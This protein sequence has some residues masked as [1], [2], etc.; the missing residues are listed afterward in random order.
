MTERYIEQVNSENSRIKS[1]LFDLTTNIY[2]ISETFILND[3]L[4]TLLSRQYTDETEVRKYFD[5]YKEIENILSQQTAIYKLN[6]YTNNASIQDYDHFLYCDESI[7]QKDWYHAL[8]TN[9]SCLWKSVERID[10]GYTY[11]D[12]T[13]YRRI[14]LPM[15]KDFAILEIKISNNYLRNRMNNRFIDSMASVNQEPVFYHNK[16]SYSCDFMPVF[17]DYKQHFYQYVGQMDING[18]PCIGTVS[19]LQPYRSNDAIYILSYSHEAVSYIHQLTVTYLLIVLLAL[20][21]P[22]F[23]LYFYTKYFSARISLLRTAMHQASQDDYNIIDSFKGNDELSETFAD[24]QIMLKKI[25]RKEAAIYQARI[26]EQ[27]LTNKQQQIELKILTSQINPHFLYN[28]LETIRMKAFNSDN[29]EVA[30]AIKLLGRYLH[31]SLESIGTTSTTLEK[32]LYYIEIYL[33]IQKLRFKNRG[34]YTIEIEENINT[35]ECKILPFLLQPIV[36]NAILHGLEGIQGRGEILIT[37]YTKNEE[38]L[39]IDVS[40]NGEG[41]NQEELENLRKTIQIKDETKTRSIGLYN[42]NQRITLCYGSEY[43]MEIDSQQGVGTRVS[44]K[45]PFEKI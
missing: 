2:N 16:Q 29:Y 19:T 40:D 9:K 31:Y 14:P 38:F 27:E 17:I 43:G 42:I 13:L 39:F 6:I 4:N 41:M 10:H 11:C 15:M 1:I 25:Q 35:S 22:C 24:L 33:K 32:E 20:F 36:E 23:L 37:V 12:L 28:T 44:L 5:S 3:E 30:D 21:I 8:S 7:Q 34:N 18:D 26:R 45:L